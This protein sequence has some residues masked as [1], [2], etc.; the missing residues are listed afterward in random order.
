ML[1]MLEQHYDKCKMNSLLESALIVDLTVLMPGS[2][3]LMKVED[4]HN[5]AVH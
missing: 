2:H 4:Y 3:R 5:M 1:E